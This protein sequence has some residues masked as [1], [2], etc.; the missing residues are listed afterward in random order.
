MKIIFQLV[1]GS[2]RITSLADGVDAKK[3]IN[4]I[5]ADMGDDYA[6]HI[7]C[8]D[9]EIPADRTF[10]NAWRRDLTVDM[11]KAREIH[12]NRM[13]E[14]RAP[15]LTELDVAFQRAMEINDTAEIEKI[16]ARKNSLRNVTATPAIAEA[17]TPEEL[18]AIWPLVLK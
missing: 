11:D 8:E 12:K 14:A 9:D 10:R 6:S 13:R 4:R 15:K 16:V 1:D 18:K 2:V 3:E 7:S 5:K 17:K